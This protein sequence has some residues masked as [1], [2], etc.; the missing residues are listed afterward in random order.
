LSSVWFLQDE[1]PGSYPRPFGIWFVHAQHVKQVPGKKTDVKDAK[2]LARLLQY[3]LLKPSYVQ[4][5]AQRELR[6]LTRYRQTHVEERSRIVNQLHQLLEAANIKLAAVVTQ[7]QGVSAQEMLQA[8][9]E[10]Q[11]DPEHLADMARGK[12]REKRAEV[13]QALAG[14]FTELIRAHALYICTRLRLG[15]SLQPTCV[16]VQK[17]VQAL[18]ADHSLL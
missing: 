15:W 12:L 7:I 10:D 17:L 8:L 4:P 5:A 6:D 11:T 1:G 3:G 9:A 14:R 18:R 16:Q 13:A 2:W